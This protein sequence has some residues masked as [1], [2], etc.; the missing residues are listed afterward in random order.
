MHPAKMGLEIVL[1]LIQYNL[2]I[3]KTKIENSNTLVNYIWSTS[4]F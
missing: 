2:K 3:S 4:A 1:Q